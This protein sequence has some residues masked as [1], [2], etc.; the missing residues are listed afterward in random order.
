MP[1]AQKQRQQVVPKDWYLSTT[2][3]GTTFQ[4][5][6]ITR[7]SNLVSNYIHASLLETEQI[8]FPVNIFVSDKI[9]L[10]SWYT[11]IHLDK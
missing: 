9:L 4:M 3:H 10:N 2:H 6:I 11:V 7:T 1:A 5:T 8:R